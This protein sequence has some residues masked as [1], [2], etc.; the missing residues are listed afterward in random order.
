MNQVFV[1]LEKDFLYWALNAVLTWNRKQRPEN[2]YRIHGSSDLILPRR[3]K[4]KYNEIIKKGTHLMLLDQNEEVSQA[5]L[6]GLKA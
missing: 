1:N 5:I 3:K 6:K 4:A 2:V